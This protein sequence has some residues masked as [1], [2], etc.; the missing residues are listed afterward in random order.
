MRA[1]TKLHFALFTVLAATVSA[2]GG[3]GGGGGGGLVATYV[4]VPNVV[5]DTI[6]QATNALQS[7]GLSLG[8]QTNQTSA[9]VPSGAIISESPA[10]G[11]NVASGTAV[12]VVVSSGPA[13]VSVPNVVSDTVSQAT[14]ALTAVGLAL[15]NQTTA[16]SAS[17]PKGEIISENPAADTNVPSGTAVSVVVSSGQPA[18][19]YAV[20]YSFATGADAQNPQAGLIQ[21]SDGNLYGTTDA[22]GASG[23]GSVFM[24]TPD[25]AETVLHSFAND[26]SD[27][28]HPQAGLALGSDGNFYGT[29]LTGGTKGGGTVF[30]ITPTGV[31]TVLHS[32]AN[33]GSDGFSPEAGLIQG[34]DGELY[35]TTAS[36]GTKNFGTVFKITSAGVETVLYS[37]TN[38]ASGD[39]DEPWAAVVQATDGNFYGTT[40]IGG[41][42]G[43]GTVFKMTP[44]GVVT[45][46]YAF[47]NGV[48]NDGVHPRSLVQGTDGNFYGT[49]AAGGANNQGTVFKITPAGAETVLYSFGSG[50]DGQDPEVGLIQGS[51]GNFYGTTQKGG[52]NGGGIVFE[53]TPAGLETLL[54]SF[55]GGNDGQSPQGPVFQATDGNFY[56]T[57]Y[58]GGTD[59]VGT[60][61]KIVP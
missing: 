39:G 13:M 60:V 8:A 54:H 58:S 7:A 41:L 32:F 53:I 35:G 24:I 37:F 28:S 36:G 38:S 42:A 20:L 33:D 5:S 45:V 34:T 23:E 59:G 40:A 6:A 19:S 25:G 16:S 9:N 11:T 50:S 1:R 18:A 12:S 61:F 30:K 14:S 26:G 43:K 27:G 29:T 21:G 56:G 17:V 51:D 52:P 22:G 15:G 55:A 47:A 48:A 10:A 49:T 31:E 44:A 46:L 57:T 3:S 4:S 2:C